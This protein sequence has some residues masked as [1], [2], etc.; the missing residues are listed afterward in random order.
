MVERN[1]RFNFF[2]TRG[3]SGIRF[4]LLTILLDQEE[5]LEIDKYINNTIVGES[6]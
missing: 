2:T 1:T 6:L 4:S 5:F 3:K